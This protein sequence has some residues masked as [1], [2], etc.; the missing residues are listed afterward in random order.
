MVLRGEIRKHIVLD[1]NTH[2]YIKS[3]LGLGCIL[4][5]SS[6]L[7]APTRRLIQYFF[8]DSSLIAFGSEL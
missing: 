1:R 8:V 7:G 6:T 3:G 4:S 2:F 5:Y